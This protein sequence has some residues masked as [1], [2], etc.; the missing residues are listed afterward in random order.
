MKWQLTGPPADA[1]GEM[2][3]VGGWVHSRCGNYSG[4]WCFCLFVGFYVHV[5][6]DFQTDFWFSY[7]IAD[8]LAGDRRW[9]GNCL[10]ASGLPSI[11]TGPSMSDPCPAV[12]RV[13][14][15]MG[16]ANSTGPRFMPSDL[17]A[18]LD[19]SEVNRDLRL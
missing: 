15:D 18:T 10:G 4:V 19:P 9:Y 12:V 1:A 3:P 8:D 16:T 7:S 5:V 2:C 11:M 6:R 14:S 17:G 13:C